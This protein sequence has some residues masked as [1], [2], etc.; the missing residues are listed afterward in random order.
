MRGARAGVNASCVLVSVPGM[1]LL[2]QTT[3]SCTFPEVGSF[4]SCPGRHWPLTNLR[5]RP[6]YFSPPFSL[7]LLS[8]I[9][10]A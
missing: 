4:V 7:R 9:S 1:R 2:L 6:G 10:I 3:H 5:H 8:K